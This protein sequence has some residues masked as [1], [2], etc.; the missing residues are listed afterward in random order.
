[1]AQSPVEFVALEFVQTG[2][3]HHR[4]SQL[5]Q[6][7]PYS[8]GFGHLLCEWTC[9]GAKLGLNTDSKT[10]VGQSEDRESSMEVIKVALTR[11]VTLGKTRHSRRG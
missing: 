3:L 9:M 11:T 8:T 7:G 1:M 2:T 5:G 6:Q 4:G 10:T